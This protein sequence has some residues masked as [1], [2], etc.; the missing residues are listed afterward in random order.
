MNDEYLGRCKETMYLKR[1]MVIKTKSRG[2]RCKYCDK[3]LSD[4]RY[5]A[6]SKQKRRKR[7]GM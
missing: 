3:L 2:C 4:L 5:E 7:W 6:E 1:H